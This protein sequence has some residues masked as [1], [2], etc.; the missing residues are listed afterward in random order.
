MVQEPECHVFATSIW[1]EV[2]TMQGPPGIAFS[3]KNSYT[4]SKEKE[5]VVGNV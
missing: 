3:G 2:T 4:F 5:E 1:K